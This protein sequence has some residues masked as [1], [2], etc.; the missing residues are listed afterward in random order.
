MV[1]R[2]RK[3]KPYRLKYG[4]MGVKV[5]DDDSGLADELRAIPGLAVDEGFGELE[6]TGHRDALS[7]ALMCIGEKPLAPLGETDSD[8]DIPEFLRPYQR[9]GVRRL[10]H[11][12]E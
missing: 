12:L 11:L 3:L 1:A 9:E 2:S 8:V 7:A 4:R 10:V 5:P 6:V